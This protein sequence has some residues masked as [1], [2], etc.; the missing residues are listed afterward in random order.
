MVG[1]TAPV[2]TLIDIFL[3]LDQHLGE[4]TTS[5]GGWTYVLLIL[6]IFCETGL[7]VMPFLPGRT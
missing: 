5:L 7:V 6:I 2:N 1:T 4:L 3:H